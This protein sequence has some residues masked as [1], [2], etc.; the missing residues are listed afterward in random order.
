MKTN[1]LLK[2]EAIRHNTEIQQE[3]AISLSLR[4]EI[5]RIRQEK[6]LLE[7][8]YYRVENALR[9]SIISIISIIVINREKQRLLAFL[10][11]AV[12]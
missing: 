10:S 2:E 6:E 8:D 5:T 9:I 11:T 12:E 4:Q 7:K 3:K 1:T